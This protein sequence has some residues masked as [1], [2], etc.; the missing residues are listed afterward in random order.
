MD[1]LKIQ[2][3]SATSNLRQYQ[4]IIGWPTVQRLLQ[5][6]LDINVL[7]QSSLPKFPGPILEL[8]RLYSPTTPM[9]DMTSQQLAHTTQ[10][11]NPISNTTDIQTQIPT[12]LD[13]D[14]IGSDRSSWRND[15]S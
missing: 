15:I 6:Y 9:L 2:F 8:I 1:P 10:T 7:N 13:D 11:P 5:V 12:K 4:N 14:R 3:Q